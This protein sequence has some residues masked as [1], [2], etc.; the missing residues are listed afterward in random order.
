MC[1]AR[2]QRS[3]W[4]RIKL[5][6]ILY[7]SHRG[8]PRCHNLSSSFCS[9]F[10]FVWVVFSSFRIDRD[11]SS[12]YFF[13]LLC[14]YLLL[15]NFQWPICRPPSS[16]FSRRPDYYITVIS[17]CQVLF[18]NFF[19]FFQAFFAP[20]KLASRLPL[21]RTALLFYHFLSWLSS[22]F[23]IFFHLFSLFV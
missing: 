15:F 13:L 19:K 16:R 2:R 21:G 1:Y 23:L 17:P 20:L 14:T 22:T 6:K 18:Q 12:H 8:I 7:Y 9:S 3:S 4:A 11:F 5:S 10:T